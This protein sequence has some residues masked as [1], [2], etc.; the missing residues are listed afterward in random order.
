MEGLLSTGPTPSSFLIKAL[1]EHAIQFKFFPLG[2]KKWKNWSDIFSLQ[3]NEYMDYIGLCFS[4]STCNEKAKKI[5]L[6]GAS[7]SM[8]FQNSDFG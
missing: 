3:V 8:Q 2:S 7:F 1:S 6:Q 5:I 4:R